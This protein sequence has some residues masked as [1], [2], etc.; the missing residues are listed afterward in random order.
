MLCRVRLSDLLGT[1][2]AWCRKSRRRNT[3]L[4]ICGK[5]ECG[6]GEGRKATGAQCPA[7]RLV[8]GDVI[9]IGE[10]TCWR[11]RRRGDIP[12]ERVRKTTYPQPVPHSVTNDGARHGTA[13]SSIQPQRLGGD[14]PGRGRCGR[15]RPSSTL[16]HLKILCWPLESRT[17]A[18]NS[19]IIVMAR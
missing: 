19:E 7:V 16:Q 13:Q 4:R 11:S 3:S 8:L 1:H 15:G 17:W 14:A 9:D 5:V 10:S 2:S 12:F 6:T 18:R